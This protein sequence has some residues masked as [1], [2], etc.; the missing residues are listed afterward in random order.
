MFGKIRLHLLI[1][2]VLFGPV[3]LPWPAF[4]TEDARFS[5][6]QTLLAVASGAMEDLT[7]N[8]FRSGFVA[9]EIGRLEAGA[10]AAIRE[11]K[12]PR[13]RIAALNRYLFDTEGFV[14]DC[15]AGNPENF[16]LEPVLHR[17]RGNCLGLAS[18]YLI[19]AE[20]ISL[21]LHG[22]HL[23]SHCLVRYDD[24]RERFNIETGERGAEHPDGRYW[25]E[26]GLTEGRPYLISLSKREM[27]GVYRKSVAAS[28]S[29]KGMGEHALRWSLEA[30]AA[31]PGLPDAW[32]NAG[33]SCL[34]LGRFAEAE[35][36]FRE[37]VRLD[38]GMAIAR[39]NLGV[40]LARQGRYRDALAEAQRAA[41]LS[42]RSPITRGNLAATLCAC[43]MVEEGI[44]EYRKVL[45]IDPSN[46]R[47]AEALANLL[48]GR[49][50]FPEAIVHT[51]RAMELGCTF[52]PA[53]LKAL[54]G[55]RA[56]TPSDLP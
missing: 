21:P 45:E 55:H 26:F 24:G 50:E 36:H 15:I 30:A 32:F 25:R 19:L 16:L 49:G 6:E 41:D 12:T 33:V 28:Y 40:A 47:A 54:D 8:A 5:F 13:E 43:G 42:P 51:E 4:A 14:Y 48:Y 22:V 44:R 17:K 9:Q 31:Y 29:R 7:G 18:L 46:A 23:P 38:P 3:V 27:A 20:R 2:L 11:G 52:D 34:K 53:M 1:V 35:R 10:R 37:A 56:E 39:D